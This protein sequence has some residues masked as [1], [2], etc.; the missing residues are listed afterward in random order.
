MYHNGLVQGNI[1]TWN[2]VFDHPKKRG[3]R[4]QFSHPILWY[5]GFGD[6]YHI[7]TQKVILSACLGPENPFTPPPK[8]KHFCG[9]NRPSC[10]TD[11]SFEHGEIPLTGL[12][13]TPHAMQLGAWQN[14][15]IY[16][17]LEF[18]GFQLVYFG[19]AFVGHQ[20]FLAPFFWPNNHQDQRPCC[21]KLGYKSARN[22]QG[23]YRKTMIEKCGVV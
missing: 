1:L 8:K 13:S 19:G 12:K 22:E 23:K 3:F 18:L 17:T 14:D 7:A 2:H 21:L 9:N 16:R 5:Q 11:K 10:F 15:D 20:I 6:S 4:F